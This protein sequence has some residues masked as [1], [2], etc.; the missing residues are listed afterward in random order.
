LMICARNRASRT[1]SLVA[2]SLVSPAA[3]HAMSHGRGPR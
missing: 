1:A 2:M 3:A